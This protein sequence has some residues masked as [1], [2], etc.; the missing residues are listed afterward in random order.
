MGTRP[1]SGRRRF[2]KF[3][4]TCLL[5]LWAVAGPDG[6]LA[7]DPPLSA[8]QIRSI[9]IGNTITFKT[10]PGGRVEVWQFYPDDRKMIFTTSRIQGRNVTTEWEI[11]ADGQ[12]CHTSPRFGLRCYRIRGDRHMLNMT[13]QTGGPDVVATVLR[14]D[15]K[16]F[17]PGRVARKAKAEA[18]AKAAAVAKAKAAATHPALIGADLPL[19]LPAKDI[20]PG[21]RKSWGYKVSLDGK[22]LAWVERVGRKPTIHVR[23]LDGSLPDLRLNHPM[24]VNAV[25]WAPDSRR[26]LFFW[27]LGT[28]HTQ[29]L[30]AADI[31]NPGAEP[32]D[33]T[34][35][36][37][38]RVL[39]LRYPTRLPG[40][41]IVRMNL[42]D[43]SVFDLHKLNLETSVHE[44]IADGTRETINW[45]TDNDGNVRAHARRLDDGGTVIERRDG[46]GE[47]TLIF[48]AAVQ[49]T[50]AFKTHVVADDEYFFARSNVGR[51]LVAAVKIS[52]KTGRQEMLFEDE[53]VD[54]KNIWASRLVDD[55][56]TAT[57]RKERWHHHYFNDPDL[58]RDIEKALS[59][60]DVDYSLRSISK[61]HMK[62][63]LLAASD[64]IG[65]ID[66]LLDRTSGKLEALSHHPVNRHFDSLAETRPVRFKSRDGL[67]LHGYL[68]LPKGTSGKGL[69]MVLKV[70]GGPWARDK[71]SYDADTQFLANRGYAVLEVNYRGSLGY[72]RAFL[73]ASRGQ[74][75]GTMHDDL[76]DAVDWAVA[77][78]YA[79]PN[80]VAIYGASYGGY[81]VLTALTK[82]PT[83]FA[84]GIDVVGMSDLILQIRTFP[85]YR[86]H[87]RN[88]WKYF[89]G[90]ISTAAGR[91]DLLERSP[92]T[93]VERIERPLLIVHGA[94]D[95]RVSKENSDRFVNKL[96]EKGIQ[97]D[98]L[99]FADEGHGIRRQKNR[100]KFARRMELF[101]AEH[102]GGRT[103][104]ERVG[105]R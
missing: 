85:P 6:S 48:Q 105:A 5:A 64:R 4:A 104:V 8:E 57:F 14:G 81:A 15:P 41:A 33:L 69:P 39:G 90:D 18:V 36:E 78:G 34:P 66:Y 102:L 60:K 65:R 24:P 42:R 38:V 79:D 88:W 44:R 37:G 91:A 13:A 7:N 93:H 97:H 50:F 12:Y 25:Y 61:D 43:R 10:G 74:F 32:R 40:H 53:N 28:R 67:T 45:I 9:L 30:F 51:E 26:L 31:E 54:V 35:F 3:V 2:G 59:V 76:I 83:K 89:V 86:K 56:V 95:T 55:I 63:V 20:Y 99:I 16:S 84:A 98:Y 92:I 100:L 29:H 49:D 52:L 21:Q 62:I 27:N 77:D 71:W 17:D 80:K 47:W 103:A 11:K 46:D 58:Q 82:T 87:A 101:L 70:H 94:R 68:T 73:E 23:W 72:G 75:A 96:R 19:I 22:K 1:E